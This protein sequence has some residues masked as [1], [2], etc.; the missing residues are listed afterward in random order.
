MPSLPAPSP[1]PGNNDTVNIAIRTTTECCSRA[2]VTNIADPV[3][4]FSKDYD[5]NNGRVQDIASGEKRPASPRKKSASSKK[6]SNT[7]SS[8]ARITFKAAARV[9]VAAIG[10][11]GLS[12]I[13]LPPVIARVDPSPTSVAQA[14]VSTTAPTPKRS[15]GPA[16]IG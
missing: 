6:K 3:I 5:D 4:L 12:D 1:H 8:P 16:M 9:A 7:S 2:A 15:S 14:G 11:V 13:A 10:A